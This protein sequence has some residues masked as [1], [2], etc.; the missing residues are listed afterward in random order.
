DRQIGQAPL[1]RQAVLNRLRFVGGIAGD[2]ERATDPNIHRIEATAAL[3]DFMLEQVESLHDRG[4]RGELVE[5]ELVSA[6][7]NPLDRAGAAGRHPDRRMRLLFGRRLD[8][9][10]LEMP[11]LAVVR[12]SLFRGPRFENEREALLEPL[13]TFL[14]R[15]AEAGE[16]VVAITLAD[17]E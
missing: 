16:L 9:D 1:R 4:G 3:L 15:H 13:L 17:P 6:L 7:G 11:V 5:Q 14:R 2:V 12:K 10:V 8:D